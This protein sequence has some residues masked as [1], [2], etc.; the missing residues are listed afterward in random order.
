MRLFATM[1]PDQGAFLIHRALFAPIGDRG[2]PSE[3]VKFSSLSA[4]A[5]NG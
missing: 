4:F 2:L 1:T 3:A 5:K